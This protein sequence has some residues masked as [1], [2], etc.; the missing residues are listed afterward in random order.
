MEIA[1]LRT[2][3]R[4]LKLYC[5]ELYKDIGR[6]DEE[7]DYFRRNSNIFREINNTLQVTL[8][9]D[10][11]GYC[12]CLTFSLE[13]VFQRDLKTLQL[14]YDLKI[15]KD[16]REKINERLNLLEDAQDLSIRDRHHN[17]RNLSEDIHCL[18]EAVNLRGGNGGVFGAE[19]RALAFETQRV[20]G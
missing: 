2:E 8:V 13:L 12:S 5:D 18:R 10:C 3:I 9:I 16:E 15:F 7:I 6:K 17:L 4:D 11:N 1:R 14:K 20:K 19:R